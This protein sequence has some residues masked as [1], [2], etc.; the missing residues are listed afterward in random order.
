MYVAIAVVVVVMAGLGIAVGSSLIAAPEPAPEV[1]VPADAEIVDRDDHVDFALDFLGRQGYNSVPAFMGLYGP[2]VRYYD[3][4]VVSQEAVAEDK[5][6]YFERWPNRYFELA[7]PVRA[8]RGATP[9]LRFDYAFAVS[10]ADLSGERE[11]RAWVELGLSPLPDGS[12][13][14][15]TSEH[16]GT[17]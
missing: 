2:Q 6:A 17:Y 11:G 13:Y 16:G 4:G 3:R 8:T 7:G 9:T 5:G 10:H 14:V 1:R 15:I 12:G